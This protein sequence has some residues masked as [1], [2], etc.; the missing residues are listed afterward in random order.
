MW[1]IAKCTVVNWIAALCASLT[2]RGGV[3]LILLDLSVAWRNSR[4]DTSFEG[5]V[6]HFIR[7]LNAICPDHG[8]EFAICW[9]RSRFIQ[10]RRS[11]PTLLEVF[12]MGAK[13]AYE[14]SFYK[15]RLFFRQRDQ[16]EDPLFNYNQSVNGDVLSLNSCNVG[17]LVNHYLTL[18]DHSASYLLTLLHLMI[19]KTLTTRSWSLITALGR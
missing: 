18:F 19:V 15:R 11:D 16:I 9:H 7:N 4:N 6:I 8:R 14:D 5:E 17:G 3:C 1:F 13:S 12:W 2:V 10:I